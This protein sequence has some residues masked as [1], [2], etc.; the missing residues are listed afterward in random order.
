MRVRSSLSCCFA[1]LTAASIVLTSCG[2]GGG[3]GSTLPASTPAAT[4]T[5]TPTPA[6]VTSQSQAVSLS[7]T[8][9]EAA[10]YSISGYSSIA[11]IPAG[12]IATTLSTTF[13]S[14]QPAGTPTIQNL[15]RRPQNIGASP[16]GS[17]AYLC[18]TPAATVSLAAFPSFTLTIPSIINGGFAYVAFYDP[19]TKSAGWN[20]IE[21]PAS[22]TGLTLG[23]SGSAPGPALQAGQTYCFLFFTLASALPTPT[24]APTPTPI[25]T[26]SPA[27]TPTAPGLAFTCPAND[28]SANMAARSGSL[29]DAD[30]VRNTTGLHAQ[31]PP[32][33]ET[34]LL[35]V[36]Y[37]ASASS[38]NS[39]S[40]LALREHS[41]GGTLVH[42]LTFARTGKMIHVI[43][44]PA[45]QAATAAATL[46]SQPGVESVAP[47]GLRR[48]VT[49]VTTPYFPNDPYFNG[50]T[51]TQNA[52][53][54]NVQP[55]T[56]QVPPY[57]ESAHVPGQWDM[58]A[59]KL[60]DALGYSQA[61]N[62]SLIVNANALGSS[63][64]KIAII[65]TGEDPNHPEIASKL[66]YQ[67]C[68]IT[69]ADGTAQSVS[70]YETDP[71][72][73][74]TDVSGI[75]AADTN[76]AFGFTGAGGN[77]T[78]AGYRVFPTPDD[79]CASDDSDDAQC[80]ASTIDI[81]DAIN[82]AVAQH[83]NVISMSLGGPAC[84][85]PGVDSDPT[86][87]AAVANAIAA[88]IIVVA[89]SGNS[90]P[91]AVGTP[92]CDSGVIA[93]GATSLADGSPN[94][95]NNGS[96]SPSSP[97][98]YVTSYTQ[99]GSVNT[100]RSAT[101]W[102]IVAP[103]GDPSSD[104][105]LDDLHWIENIWTT[106]PFQSSPND[107]DFTGECVDDY[108]NGNSL[109][110]PVDCRTEIAGTSMA[111]PHVAG[112]AALILSA[113][114]GSSS[115]YQSPSAMRTLLCSTADDIGGAHQGCGRLNVYTAMA[116]ALNDPSPPTP[117]P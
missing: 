99:F 27:A 53:D 14:A 79:N 56:F 66:V 107:F 45:S 63:S 5:A 47:T 17:L 114:G 28:S 39:A 77:V 75:A 94:G 115:P 61:G 11:T 33:G 104:G 18:I 101:S 31:H 48:Y 89:A 34:G 4:A 37:S 95:S 81:A 19:T 102:G 68:F 70:S 46:R 86:E 35:A 73:H 41:A 92:A 58:H 117:L 15:R 88:G 108:P 100:I 7:T 84:S 85:S 106:T 82:D 51:A 26:A 76:N 32:S 44:V 83:V 116:T 91:G 25:V 30:A 93:V 1:L 72:G 112:A 103:G 40:T 3:G 16:I 42:Q 52:S 105:D 24:P 98:E 8:S 29:G 62:G 59:I 10:A 71:F 50:F 57:E 65:D 113:T 55:S 97:V 38:A 109:N 87:G 36:T 78:I 13:S 64:V 21:G 54:N 60:D 111:T 43:S 12:N 20:T 49:K 80:G 23:F 67:H 90:G 96:G 74:G 6:P 2:G 110:A 9:S 69:N 22:G